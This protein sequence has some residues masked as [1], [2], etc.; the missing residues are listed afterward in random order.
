MKICGQTFNNNLLGNIQEVITQNPR[1]TSRALSKKV[2]EWLDWRASNGQWQEGGCRSALAKLNRLGAITL[3]KYQAVGKRIPVVMHQPLQEIQC[4]LEQL[5]LV[6][7]ILIDNYRS[8][9]AKLWRSVM[10]QH[11]YLGD[12]SLCGGQLKYLAK[13]SLGWVGALAFNSC[14]FALSARDDFIKWSENAKNSNLRLIVR[15]S[16]FLILPNVKVP[17]LA[18]YLLSQALKRME[19]D[20]K[21]RY[22]V[23]PVLVETFVNLHRFDGTCYRAANWKEIGQT[24][25]RRSDG[26]AKAVFVYPLHNKWQEI[27]RREPALKLAA[28]DSAATYKHWAEEEFGTIRLH[29][30]RLK[31][32]LYTLAT[33]FYNNPQANIP[34]ACKSKAGSMGAYRFFQNSKISMDV[35]L[36][37]HVESTIKR[38]KAHRIVLAPQDTTTLNYT[39]LSE[40]T[41]LGPIG[42]KASTS[43]G[44]L[45]HD[46]VAFTTD[47]VPLGVLDAQCWARDSSKKDKSRPIE[48]KES[49]KWLRSYRRVAEVQALCP[50]TMLV[51]MGDRESDIYDLFAEAAK[52]V[53]GPKLLIRAERT[54]NRCVENEERLW[55]YMSEQ[56]EEGE[57]IMSIPK[58]GNRAARNA[59]IKVRF[60]KVELQPPKESHFQ[61]ITLWAVHL[62]E[63][64]PAD[65]KEPIEWMLLTTVPTDTFEQAIERSEWYAARWG[66]EIY[67]RT[68]KSG[69]RIKD[70]QLGS[71]ERLQ[72]CLGIDMVVAWRI[73]HMTMLGREVPDQPCTRFFEEVEWKALYCY[74]HQTTITPEE[75]PSMAEALR[76][77]GTL[78]GHLG[79]KS[80]GNPGTEVLW[81]GL[82][83]LDVAVQMY[84]IFTTEKEPKS[85]ASYPTSYIFHYDDSS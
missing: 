70:R 45:L 46:T 32:R 28:P 20:W 12:K 47:G 38:I 9:E 41:G 17:N 64:E 75:P 72:A 1:I 4:S 66:I 50:E 73:Y 26:I 42:T 14:C 13:C 62:L 2:C 59:V 49:A 6:E 3:P 18:S 22:G 82:Q 74:R 81:R 85:W 43:V 30:E 23:S 34:E 68:L 55:S 11:H 24:S 48:E 61:P 44:L 63:I 69:C 19:I 54:R 37:P 16:R 27:L 83:K 71:A 36:T 65:K 79:R 10:Q 51:S 57:M 78:G 84:I 35:I 25:G 33:N 60:K 29:D 31:E 15:N 7:L 56:L 58:R 8:K 5:G 53:A 77:L 80:D 21:I 67:H 52:N 76:M 40:A 39:Y